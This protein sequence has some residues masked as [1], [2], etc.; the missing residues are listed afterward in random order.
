MNVSALTLHTL[1]T[2]IG[3]I[4]LLQLVWRLAES[5]YVF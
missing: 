5:I 3:T 1:Y 2:K 4:A